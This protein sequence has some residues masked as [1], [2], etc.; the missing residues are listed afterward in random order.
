MSF[1]NRIFHGK[2]AATIPADAALVIT[3]QGRDALQEYGGDPRSRILLA[4]ETRGS[5]D[6]AKISASSGLTP[7]QVERAVPGLLN[8]GYAR[9]VTTGMAG[10]DI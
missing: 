7:G 3:E 1:F 6:I 2:G 4:L 9:F 10:D 8:S 5:C